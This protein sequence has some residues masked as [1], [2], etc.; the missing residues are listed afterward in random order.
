MLRIG[1]LLLL[2]GG[3]AAAH[4]AGDRVQ[5]CQASWDQ[6][7]ASVQQQG[8]DYDSKSLLQKWLAQE[9]PCRG[10][11][12]YEFRLAALYVKADQPKRALEVLN[13]T[14][15]FPAHYASLVPLLKLRAELTILGGQDP[16]P[17][18][19]IREL[20]PQFVAALR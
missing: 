3:L 14:K 7:Y 8:D 1:W 18:D 9:G 11:G 13:G 12:V 6:T 15:S 19:K 2:A 4:A 5:S 10:T 16:I 20:K 17:I